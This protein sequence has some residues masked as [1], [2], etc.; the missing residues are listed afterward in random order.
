MLFKY[1]AKNREGEIREGTLEAKDRIALARSLRAEGFYVL[2]VSSAHKK[3]GSLIEKIVKLDLAVVTELIRGVPLSEKMLF[4]RNLAVM[5]SSGIPLVRSLSVLLRQTKSPFLKNAIEAI[6]IDIEK[7]SRFSNALARH[8]KIFS[9]LYSSMV[10]AGEATGKLDETLELLS[11]QLEKE[12][13][14]K[15]R[16]KGALLYPAVI[17]IALVGIGILMMVMVVPNLKAVFE[18]LGT[19]LPPTTRAIILLSD[20]LRFYWWAF[21][22]ALP[23]II[24]GLKFFLDS[25]TGK[26]AM[27]WLLLH[28][29]LFSG[30]VKKINNASFA[31]TL[32]SL[33]AGGVPI[34][35][36][37]QI[38]SRTLGNVYYQEAVLEA[39]N[40]V[41][42]GE[43]LYTI[44]EQY[45]HLYT[46]LVIEMVQV[47]EETGKLSDLL[48]RIAEF[49]EGEVYEITKNLSTIIEPVLMLFI[50]GAVGFFAISIMQPIYGMMGSL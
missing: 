21:V 20:A 48:R 1:K 28:I 24:V 12:H 2:A 49:Y 25:S 3:G 33:I 32:G 41:K 11:D 9:P 8:P 40:K 30:L 31:R 35:K 23:V 39:E 50:G 38:T 45:P 17:I 46:P 22:G 10:Q 14:L 19:E 47:G 44:L 18:D 42:K 16:I 7:G 5:I 36:S 15:S 34:L 26:R 29:P 43:K 13:E 4:S 27:A 37:L 6:R